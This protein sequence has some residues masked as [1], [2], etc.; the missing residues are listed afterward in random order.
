MKSGR[1]RGADW[2]VRV[3]WWQDDIYRASFALV[4]CA[5]EALNP[6]L[7]RK[8]GKQW[9]VDVGALGQPLATTIDLLAHPKGAVMVV[10]FPAQG[11]PTKAIDTIAH[12]AFH[13]AVSVLA[14]RRVELSVE[15]DEPW[16][17]Y[18]GFLTREIYRR[19]SGMPGWKRP[20]RRAA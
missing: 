9:Q 13:C 11:T 6:W 20:R 16:A 19:L 15:N 2:E 4:V 12:E 14:R 17:Y 7:A 10:W 1:S 3:A 18:C 8:F 5:R